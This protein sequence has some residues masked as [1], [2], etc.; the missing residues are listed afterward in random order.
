MYCITNHLN[1][2]IGMEVKNTTHEKD[3]EFCYTSKLYYNL[4]QAPEWETR[5]KIHGGKILSRVL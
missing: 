2:I 1:N 3:I 5:I 4:T